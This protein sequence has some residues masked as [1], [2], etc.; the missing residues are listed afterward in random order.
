MSNST[1]LEIDKDEACIGMF[2]HGFGKQWLSSPFAL[3]QFKLSSNDELKALRES[4]V[5]T[6]FIDLS[7]GVGPRG[8]AGAGSK[9]RQ[10]LGSRAGEAALTQ[11][12]GMVRSIFTS[13]NSPKGIDRQ[14]VEAVVDVVDELIGTPSSSR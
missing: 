8:A 3:S 1:L 7:R 6:V 10:N 4:S 5:T 9:S 11:A 13:A 14:Q 2:I 12:T